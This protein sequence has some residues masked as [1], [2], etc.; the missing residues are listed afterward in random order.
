MNLFVQN[1]MNDRFFANYIVVPG[2]DLSP[3][4]LRIASVCWSQK[5]LSISRSLPLEEIF[6]EIWVVLCL[7]V[8]KKVNVSIMHG[9]AESA[10]LWISHRKS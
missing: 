6:K 4:L 10:D 1:K 9:Q 2:A 5:A 3:W 7:D 8:W